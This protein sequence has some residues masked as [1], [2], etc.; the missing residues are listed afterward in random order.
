MNLKSV[1]LQHL[2]QHKHAKIECK[3]CLSGGYRDHHRCIFE[4]LEIGG[5]D[6]SKIIQQSLRSDFSRD[7]L[8]ELS[9][10]LSLLPE[11]QNDS[12]FYYFCSLIIPQPTFQLA[13]DLRISTTNRY[14]TSIPTPEVISRYGQAC[15]SRFLYRGIRLNSQQYEI[16]TRLKIGD[17]FQAQTRILSTTSL[18]GRGLDYS[19]RRR[20]LD[21]PD[22]EGGILLK[23][24][25]AKGLPISSLSTYP[26]EREWRVTGEFRVSALDI[27]AD[28]IE[29]LNEASD[30]RLSNWNKPVE[31]MKNWSIISLK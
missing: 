9:G 4:N 5:V 26:A 3:I 24:E 7:E 16:V 25:N 20:P 14:S 10:E 1:W 6:C 17:I 8:L 18:F 12:H 30:W 19:Y 27:N 28:P 13:E 29:Y 11:T 15:P 21:T 2:E 31:M 23:I 22:M